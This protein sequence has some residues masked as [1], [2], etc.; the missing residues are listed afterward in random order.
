MKITCWA[1]FLGWDL[2][3]LIP[4]CSFCHGCSQLSILLPGNLG[5][6]R[7]QDKTSSKCLCSDKSSYGT[8]VCPSKICITMP[9][10]IIRFS[11]VAP[12]AQRCFCQFRTEITEGFS[13][14][15]NADYFRNSVLN[16][17]FDCGLSSCSIIFSPGNNIK[18]L[19]KNYVM[20][21]PF[22]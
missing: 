14:E 3:S 9:H 19:V 13:F 17:F 8:Q 21:A 1:L 10:K 5:T 2:V 4:E 6:P 18:F 16:I 11:P 20:A 7:S 15:F 12:S 22:L